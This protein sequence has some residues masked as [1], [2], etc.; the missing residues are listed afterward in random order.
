MSSTS[1]ASGLRDRELDWRFLLPVPRGGPLTT[2]RVVSHDPT[3]IERARELSVADVIV[4]AGPDTVDGVVVL[5]GRPE[6]VVAA[7]AGVRPG[8]V[9][10]GE[11]EPDG[12]RSARWTPG[13]LIR[14]L[15][16]AGA[17]RPAVYWRRRRHGA[18]VLYIPLD[19][20]GALPWYLREA[21]DD[22]G[23]R[24][25]VVRQLVLPLV[26]RDA[27][28]LQPLARRYSVAG[29]VTDASAD[30]GRGGTPALLHDATGSELRPVVLAR[31]SGCW[32]RVVLLP[33]G[34]LDR[35]PRGVV[36]TPRRRTHNEATASE[37]ETLTRL[38]DVL[39]PSLAA[40][41][42]SPTGLRYWSEL[43]VGTE[44]FLP[45]RPLA[46]AGDQVPGWPAPAARLEG[47]VRWLVDFGLATRQA[48]VAADSPEAA[49]LVDEPVRRCVERLGLLPGSTIDDLVR[50]H[51]IALAGSRTLPLV[52]THCDLTPRNMRWN[53]QQHAVVD[54]E[55]ARVGPPLGDLCYLLLH[56]SWPGLPSFDA[57]PAQAFGG[58]L[59]AGSALPARVSA[60]HVARYCDALEIDLMLVEPLVLA[61][62]AQQAL[63]RADRVQ[64]CG[65]DPTTDDN[66]YAALV[67]LVLRGSPVLGSLR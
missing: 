40:T 65:V 13:R 64:A 29:Q 21:L 15:R 25:R 60:H 31:G 43:A 30:R 2:L 20:P 58:S 48:R 39:A 6:D 28:R 50:P 54:W 17:G 41:V 1:A 37:Q 18:D 51:A 32:S 10:Y 42:P 49:R 34:A 45:G 67:S 23:L 33:F 26:P 16:R 57:D 47:A 8:G 12:A 63:D 9:F 35:T 7:L 38:S 5:T 27:S 44:R 24:R 52:W 62:L 56:W 4:A 11:V 66:R 55:A 46:F 19:V 3:T 61:M 14:A 36:K 59:G 53:G 22:R